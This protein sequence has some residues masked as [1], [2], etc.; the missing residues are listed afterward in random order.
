MQGFT[1]LQVPSGCKAPHISFRTHGFHWNP[2]S[3]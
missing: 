2:I 3:I 1:S